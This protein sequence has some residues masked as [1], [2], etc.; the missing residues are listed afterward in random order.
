MKHMLKNISSLGLTLNK[1]E[2]KN[3]K[4]GRRN[5]GTHVQVTCDFP[6]GPGWEGNASSTGPAGLNMTQHCYDGG[7][8]P[9]VVFYTP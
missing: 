9:T 3:I 6:E 7:G 5:I 1:S 8:T 4:G 2:L